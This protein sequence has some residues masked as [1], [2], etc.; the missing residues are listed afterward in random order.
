[1]LE[2][3]VEERTSGIVY[4]AVPSF[5]PGTHLEFPRL[6][7]EVLR[8]SWL[9]FIDRQPNSDWGHS[10]RYLLIDDETGEIRSYPAQ[11]PPFAKTAPWRWQVVYKAPT[12]P[13][14]A[15]SV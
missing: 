1:V 2:D 14:A 12:L 8:L 13:N 10:C 3:T 4:L 9:A 6:V 5:G 11:F 7:I 15:A